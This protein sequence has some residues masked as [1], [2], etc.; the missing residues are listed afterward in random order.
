LG[1]RDC[2]AHFLA[3]VNLPRGAS[4]L[5]QC[6]ASWHFWRHDHAAFLWAWRRVVCPADAAHLSRMIGFAR[7][8]TPICCS[9]VCSQQ[10]SLSPVRCCRNRPRDGVTDRVWDFS[11][12]APCWRRTSGGDSCRRCHVIVGRAVPPVA[13]SASFSASSCYRSV[14]R[15]RLLP[16]SRCVL[17]AYAQ[18]LTSPCFPVHHN[19]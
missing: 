12:A 18:L 8:A 13:R 9:P 17:C 7:A 14:L 2:H 11:S 10:L 3:W 1:S 4:A 15:D 19:V 6:W 16:W 5:G